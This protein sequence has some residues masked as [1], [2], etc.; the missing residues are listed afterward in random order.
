[1]AQLKELL[2]IHE[3]TIIKIFTNRIKNL[4][5]K[6]TSMQV[7]N[8]QQNET[9]K[10]MKRDMTEETQK[11]E[12]DYKNNEVVQNLIQQNT[13]MKEQIAELED[14]LGRNNLQFM[15]IKWKSGVENE[16]WRESETKVKVFL[17]EKLGLETDEITI[18]RVNRAGKK[19]GEKRRTIIAKFLNCK[20]REK[21]LNKYKE[22]KLWEN[23]IYKNEDFSEYTV[24]K[25]RIL[26]K[27]GK[28]IRE[29]GEFTKVVYNRLVSS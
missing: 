20:Q 4:G 25:R 24:E 15:G 17:Q 28:E 2:Y 10:K 3:N 23:Q 22:L 16:A 11:L 12:T 9:Y 21:V 6:I 27:R 18:E 26:F 29:R 5:S 14:R 19:E 7:E 8:K 1:M 13:D